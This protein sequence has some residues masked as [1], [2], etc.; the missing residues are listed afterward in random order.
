MKKK[1]LCAA[2]SF[3]FYLTASYIML[4]AQTEVDRKTESGAGKKSDSYKSTDK[5]SQEGFFEI[6]GILG[7][8]SGLNSRYWIT[9]SFGLDFSLG[10][11]LNRD[12]LIS[13]DLLFEPFALY[14]AQDHSVRF[15]IGAGTLSGYVDK[16]QYWSLRAPVGLSMPF[17]AYPVAFSLY[18]APSLVPVPDS[19]FDVNWGIA[20][21]YNFGIASRMAE[22]ERTLNSEYKALLD[23]HDQMNDQLN[24]TKSDLDKTIDD[25]KKTR[26]ELDTAKGELAITKGDMGKTIDRLTMTRNE[27]EDTRTRLSMTKESLDSAAGELSDAKSRLNSAR[28]QIVI[29][30]KELDTVKNEL[31][32]TREELGRAKKRI[33]DRESDLRE[34]QAELANARNFIKEALT[35]LQK[36]QEEK[37]LEKQQEQLNREA[38]ALRKEKDV[39]QKEHEKQKIS[40]ERL[41]SECES[42]RGIINED[43]YCDCRPHEQW[44]SDRSACVCVKGYQ[45]NRAT[46]RCEPCETVKFNGDCVEGC[47]PDEGRVTLAKGPHKFVCVKRCTKSNEVWSDR[48]NTCVCRDGFYRDPSG[49]CVPRR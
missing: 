1:V 8:P 20:A 29:M 15:F 48:K 2:V 32:S 18:V 19:G 25:L 7:M 12:F 27:L 33:D 17:T 11:T 14:R 37:K 35:G 30:R 22:R 47:G 34:K 43:G 40:R 31:D 24:K 4:F 21:R 16:G 41:K 45:L 39:W 42:R 26:G 28:D 36:E 6:G 49:E 46:D 23:R 44:N 5:F 3:L 10:S 9:D 38:E 13:F